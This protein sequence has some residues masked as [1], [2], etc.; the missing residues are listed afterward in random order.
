[1][2]LED[3]TAV[4]SAAP[5]D[6]ER[7]D[8]VR[9]IVEENCLGKQTTSTRKLS[10]QRISELYALDP[11]VPL[12]HVLRECWQLDRDGRPLLAL[13]CSIARDPLLVATIPSVLPLPVGAEFRRD[14]MRAALRK[15]VGQRMNDS[16]LDKVARNAAS[17]WTQSGHLSG[18]TFKRRQQVRPTPAAVAYAIYLAHIV[19]FR[20]I[21]L[22][23][24]GWLGLLDCSP[25]QAQDLALDAK[26]MQLLDL[27]ISGDV[28]DVGF[29]RLDPTYQGE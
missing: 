8:Y 19:G 7:A 3:L 12:F 13:L 4:L 14:D 25:S 6:A 11:A 16:I 9:A 22:F 15:A 2:M 23:S 1:M 20:G 28:V 29:R 26:R 27:R 24:S 17:S 21:S 10:N 5:P 18:R